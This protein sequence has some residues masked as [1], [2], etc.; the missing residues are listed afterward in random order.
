MV[1]NYMHPNINE[2]DNKHMKSS[3]DPQPKAKAKAGNMSEIFSSRGRC[4]ATSPESE[5]DNEAV[6]VKNRTIDG[7]VAWEEEEKK[8]MPLKDSSV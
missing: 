4:R 3:W 2:K 5:V 7:T 6:Q 8:A 1:C